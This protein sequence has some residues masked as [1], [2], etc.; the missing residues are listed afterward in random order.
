MTKNTEQYDL[1]EARRK[2]IIVA[3]FGENRERL[4]KENSILCEP[5]KE[6]EKVYIIFNEKKTKEN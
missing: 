4:K 2:N 6:V 5:R 1:L 3:T